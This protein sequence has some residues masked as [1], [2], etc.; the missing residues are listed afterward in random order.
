MQFANAELGVGCA[1]VEGS[2]T[3]QGAVEDI[4]KCKHLKLSAVLAHPILINMLLTKLVN[5]L[6]PKN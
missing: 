2:V 5:V 1:V 3:I 6:P 4:G